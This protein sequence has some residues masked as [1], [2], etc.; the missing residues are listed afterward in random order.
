MSRLVTARVQEHDERLNLV[1]GFSDGEQVYA[2][3]P[4]RDTV[5]DI[6]PVLEAFAESLKG[7][8]K[9]TKPLH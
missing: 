5:E 6:Q 3:L 1:L 8:M 2:E 7:C 4:K 9:E